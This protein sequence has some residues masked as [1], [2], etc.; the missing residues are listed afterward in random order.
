MD[1]LSNIAVMMGRV[2]GVSMQLANSAG[3]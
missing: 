3:D 1:C 2:E